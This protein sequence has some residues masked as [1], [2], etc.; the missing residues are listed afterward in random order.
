[1]N[2]ARGQSPAPPCYTGSNPD[3]IYQRCRESFESAKKSTWKKKFQ[4]LMPFYLS[5]DPG[6]KPSIGCFFGQQ[7]EIRGGKYERVCLP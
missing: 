6:S 1:M 7:I 4:V 2:A 3:T 5:F